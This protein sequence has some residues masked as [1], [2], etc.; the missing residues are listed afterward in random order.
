[1][2]R[3]PVDLRQAN[4]AVKAEAGGHSAAAA[5]AAERPKQL[6][7]AGPGPYPGQL[8]IRLQ[9]TDLGGAYFLPLYKPVTCDFTAAYQLTAGGAGSSV[10]VEGQLNGHLEGK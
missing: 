5:A 4:L 2:N 10:T 6:R 3:R 1:L 8:I 9:K 7:I